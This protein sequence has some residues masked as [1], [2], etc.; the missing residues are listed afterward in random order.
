MTKDYDRTIAIERTAMS[1]TKQPMLT[2]SRIRAWFRALTTYDLFPD[3]SAKVRRLVYHPLGV[4]VFSALAGL[5]GGLFLHPQGFVFFGGISAVIALGIAWPW[6]SLCG[7]HGSVSFARTR[8]CEGEPVEAC[9][10]LRNRWFWSIWGLAVRGGFI[11]APKEADQAGVVISVASAPGRRTVR[12][13]WSFVPTCRG[14]YPLGAPR[15][16]TGFPFGLWERKKPLAVETSLIVRP[17]TYPVGPVPPGSADRQVEGNV[18]RNKV[19]SNGDVLGVRPFRRGDSPRRIH[20][21]QSARHDRLIV[22]ELQANARPVIQLVLDADARVHGGVGADGSREWAIRIVASLAKGWLEAGAQVGVVWHGNV[23]RPSSGQRHLIHVLD[24][25]AK[26]PDSAGSELATTLAGPAC[27]DFRDG[28]QVIVTTDVA[29]ARTA[30]SAGEND[31][32]RW[33]VLQAAAF[34]ASPAPVLDLPLAPWL[35]ID[36]AE[37]VPTLLRGGWREARHGS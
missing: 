13:K 33:V 29:L 16:T 35:W 37:H 31:Q 14:V 34:G 30:R 21:A 22:C 1:V 12:C 27:R 26:L 19:G 28:L 11:K 18:S 10:T 6:L 15:I 23:I 8:V 3:F 20:W 2:A 36:S 7:L 25:L 32:R 17:K 9:L 24:S 4:L 5:L